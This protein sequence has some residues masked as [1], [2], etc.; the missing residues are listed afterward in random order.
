MSNIADDP[1]VDDAKEKATEAAGA[2]KQRAAQVSEVAQDS[3]A[4]SALVTTAAAAFGAGAVLTMFVMRRIH[5][6]ERRA[7]RS[8][9]KATKRARKTVKR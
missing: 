8:A 4:K 1:K 7:R 3:E 9:R 5:K 6:A 2:A